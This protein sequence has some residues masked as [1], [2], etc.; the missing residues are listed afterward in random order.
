MRTIRLYAD[1]MKDKE[2]AHAYLAKEL[3]F[4]EYYGSNLDA[5]FDCLTEFCG[6]AFIIIEGSGALSKTLGDYGKSLI[7][8]FLNAASE[9]GMYVIL[10]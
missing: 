8:V 3:G 9:S 6:D 7:K 10:K 5:L 2:S 4:P 1:K